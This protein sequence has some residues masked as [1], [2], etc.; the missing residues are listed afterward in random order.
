ML[1]YPNRTRIS[2]RDPAYLKD[3]PMNLNCR[4]ASPEFAGNTSTAMVRAGV[5]DVGFQ[6]ATNPSKYRPW[7][8][9]P[10]FHPGPLNV[11]LSKAPT[12]KAAEYDGNGKW[13]KIHTLG[14]N[15]SVPENQTQQWYPME[16]TIVSKS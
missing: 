2:H 11:Y 14:L 13:F 8:P 10:I 12:G 16:K 6:S 5:D 15:E 4:T 7:Q 9:W 3:A 1:R